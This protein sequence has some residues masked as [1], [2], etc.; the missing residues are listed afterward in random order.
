MQTTTDYFRTH[1]DTRLFEQRWCP[2]QNPKAIIALVHGY[3]EH[4]SR[5]QYFAQRC[6]EAGISVEAYDLR[7]HGRSNGRRGFVQNFQDYVQDLTH[8]LQRVRERNANQPLFLL[9][10]SLGGTMATYWSLQESP[11]LNG[12]ILSGAALTVGDSI[13]RPMQY[14]AK[15]LSRWF[16]NLPTVRV[17]EG[18][19]IMRDPSTIANYNQDR[20]VYRARVPARAAAEVLRAV[21]NIPMERVL[22]PLLILHGTADR[23]TDPKG[24]AELYKRARATDKTFKSYD[25]LYHSLLEE[26]ERDQVMADILSW[27]PERIPSISTNT[28]SSSPTT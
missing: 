19:V 22:T 4:S 23:V 1:D 15:T 9:G 13:S 12:L 20:L 8:F 24:S 10:H 7:G 26:P 2:T 5:Y 3:T 14:V 28:A 21:E 25:G 16:P 18:S 17:G 11:N 27:I 6:V